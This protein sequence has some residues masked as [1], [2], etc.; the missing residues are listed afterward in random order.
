M[1]VLA[2]DPGPHVGVATWVDGDGF[3]CFEQ[4][5]DELYA[6]IPDWISW[7]NVVV[8]EN[9]IIKGARAKEANETIEMIGVIR[10]LCAQRGRH[11]VLQAPADAMSFSTSEKLKRIGWWQRGGSDHGRAASKHL[12]LYMVKSG[13]L[14]ADRVLE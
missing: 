13:L 7:A 5:P 12:L 6:V 1:K 3:R 9:F 8:C 4:T 2:I 14:S 11:F 10:Y